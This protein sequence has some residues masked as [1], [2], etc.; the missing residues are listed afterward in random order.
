MTVEEIIAAIRLLAPED[1]ERLR[2][3]IEEI[4]AEFYGDDEEFASA[5]ML[6]NMNVVLQS[7]QGN[8][9]LSQLSN[10]ASML[11]LE[12]LDHDELARHFGGVDITEDEEGEA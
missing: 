10:L 5:E 9:D 2:D 8:I 11:N 6:Q 7:L 4:D 3:E 12:M 1:Y